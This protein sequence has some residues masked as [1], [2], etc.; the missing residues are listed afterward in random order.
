MHKLPN[1]P[2]ALDALEPHISRETLEFHYGKHHRAY[3]EKLNK[4][5]GNTE[6]EKLDLEETVRRA[7][8]QVQTGGDPPEDPVLKKTRAILDNASQAWNHAFYWKCLTPVPRKELPRQLIDAINSS[9][10]SLEEFKAHFNKAAGEFV[11]AAWAWLVADGAGKLSVKIT[12]NAH[13]LLGE[14][15]GLLM[16]CD[17]WEHAYYIDRRNEKPAYLDAFW[18]VLNW[19]CVADN[20]AIAAKAGA[21]QKHGGQGAAQTRH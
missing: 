13:S 16:V 9:F 4:L 19:D 15:Y 20:Y 1:L 6:Y 2:F 18:H 10:G 11:G 7:A 12:S 14:D 3:V 8:A 5:I 17:L 21:Q